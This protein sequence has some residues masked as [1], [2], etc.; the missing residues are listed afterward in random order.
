MLLSKPRWKGLLKLLGPILFIFLLIRVVDPRAT[1]ELLKA[2][3]P[4]MVLIS[5]LLFPG[6]IAVLTVRWWLVCQRLGLKASFKEL[7]HIYYTAWFLSAL[8]LVGISP[9]AKLIYLKEEGKPAD[10]AAISIVLDKLLDV[11]GHLIF[12]IF[13]FFY[14]PGSIFKDT[15]LW[16]FF[17][18]MLILAFIILI[19]R[20]KIW[21]FLKSFL[22]RYTNK[23]LQGIGR[24]IE[25]KLMGFWA[26]FNIQFFSPILG[27]SIAI[28]LL[29]SL[30][31]YLLAISLDIPVSFGFIIACRALIGIVNV[32]PVTINGLGTRDSILLLTLP[33][34]GVPKEA[35]IALGLVAF[36]WVI[37]SKFSGVVFWLKRP[38]PT[39]SLLAIK[40]KL[41]S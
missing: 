33:L 37:C 23:K 21:I 40:E 36:L 26:N 27:I 9:I 39:S 18:G 19:L 31:L 35:A 30:V 20:T 7:F 25:I 8:P 22:K 29:R 10:V 38:L 1:A 16:S 4:E 6:V 32:I 24:N 28:G 11:I 34:L 14:F 13:G 5:I 41:L 15:Q 17:G 12:G 2:I 3:R